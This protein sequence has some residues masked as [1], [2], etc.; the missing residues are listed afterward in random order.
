M[1][2]REGRPSKLTPERRKALVDAIAAG[3]YYEPACRA[4]GI[5][6]ATFRAWFN[7]GEVQQS[8]NYHEFYEDVLR[9]EA[10]AELRLVAQWQLAMPANPQEIKHFLARRYP[11]RWANKEKVEQ[12]GS[13]EHVIKVV[14]ADEGNRAPGALEAPASATNG[15][16]ALPGQT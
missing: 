6:Y 3:S 1:P 7:K 11:E 10:Q 15:V 4:N 8:G 13:I 5:P 9:A 16:H 2:R 12:S 14:Y